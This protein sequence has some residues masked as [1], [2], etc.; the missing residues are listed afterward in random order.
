M[1]RAV[2]VGEHKCQ[3]FIVSIEK[4]EKACPLDEQLQ[5]TSVDWHSNELRLRLRLRLRG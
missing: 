5:P 2:N 3:E 1:H 4:V